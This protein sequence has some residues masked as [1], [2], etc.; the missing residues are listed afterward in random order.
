[1]TY[2]KIYRSLSFEKTKLI[3]TKLLCPQKNLIIVT[4]RAKQRGAQMDKYKVKLNLNITI[5][6]NHDYG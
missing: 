4:A 1:M 6:G 3:T 2:S 5:W